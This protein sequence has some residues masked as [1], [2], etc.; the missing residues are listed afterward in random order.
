MLPQQLPSH[1]AILQG[2]TD[3]ELHKDEDLA[4]RGTVVAAVESLVA[5]SH[6]ASQPGAPQYHMGINQNPTGAV[7]CPTP[8]VRGMPWAAGHQH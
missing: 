7:E 8:A 5:D 4:T 2:H 6:A 1:G 3:V